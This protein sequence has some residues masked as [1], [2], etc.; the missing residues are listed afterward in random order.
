MK[1]TNKYKEELNFGIKI[2]NIMA[3]VDQLDMENGNTL[4]IA[5]IQKKVDKVRIESTLL[6]E[7]ENPSIGSKYV[8]YHIIFDMK[9]DIPI[10]GRL[11]ADEHRHKNAPKNMTYFSVVPIESVT[12]CFTIAALNNM[13]IVPGY[14]GNIH[15]NTNPLGSTTQPSKM[16]LCLYQLR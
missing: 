8:G 3:E 15:F 6:N 12:I 16:I 7:G 10:K 14:I 2:P 11:M 13:N 9:M 4:W 5:P 1:P